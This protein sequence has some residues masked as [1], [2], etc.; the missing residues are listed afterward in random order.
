MIFLIFQYS[1]SNILITFC[2][3]FA[4]TYETGKVK[5][6][7][8]TVLSDA[9]NTD[10]DT[11]LKKIR[12]IIARKPENDVDMHDEAEAS[13]E[14][15]ATEGKPEMFYETADS[16]IT[17]SYPKFP[18]ISSKK[19]SCKNIRRKTEGSDT[20]FERSHTK[21]T[22]KENHRPQE[23]DQFHISHISTDRNKQNKAIAEQSVLQESNTSKAHFDLLV[24]LLNSSIKLETKVNK[25]ISK[26]EEMMMKLNLLSSGAERRIGRSIDAAVNLPNLPIRSEDDLNNVELQLE[27]D[28]FNKTLVRLSCN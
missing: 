3:I 8:V 23:E 7:Q 20:A 10:D 6:N 28:A 11:E 19:S 15:K 16:E 9:P 22:T 12:Q 17:K 24:R 14:K 13:R 25:I 18:S 5:L 21:K 27:D 2:N 1:C 4:G 26:Q